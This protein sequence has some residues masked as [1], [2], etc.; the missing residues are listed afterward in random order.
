ME[1]LLGVIIFELDVGLGGG[2]VGGAFGDGV[3]VEGVDFVAVG[4]SAAGPLDEF[5]VMV[6]A[7]PDDF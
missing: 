5:V 7:G 1:S 3:V 4:V 2:V 6:G